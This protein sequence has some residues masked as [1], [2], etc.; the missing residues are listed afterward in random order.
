LPEATLV[1]DGGDKDVRWLVLAPLLCWFHV[2]EDEQKALRMK[3]VK[4]GIVSTSTATMAH[5]SS[6]PW[7]LFLFLHTMEG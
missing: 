1:D 2:T 5:S 4:N 7:W 6:L 3:R